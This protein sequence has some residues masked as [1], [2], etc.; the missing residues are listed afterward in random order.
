[1]IEPVPDAVATQPLGVVNALGGSGSGLP[2]PSAVIVSTTW[3][4][5]LG[6]AFVKLAAR[7]PG[8]VPTAFSVSTCGKTSMVTP[9][10]TL[11]ARPRP[12]RLAA[13][14]R[15]HASATAIASDRRPPGRPGRSGLCIG[16]LLL[17]WCAAG[18]RRPKTVASASRDRNHRFAFRRTCQ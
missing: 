1:M 13:T 15:A 11:P 17:S 10:R 2:A 9:V 5:V 8:V 12:T 18:G 4:T 6:P 7:N 16:L 14:A 3:L